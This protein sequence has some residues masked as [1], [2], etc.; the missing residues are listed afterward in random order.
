MA[1]LDYPDAD[2]QHEE[3]NALYEAI[4]SGKSDDAYNIVAEIIKKEKYLLEIH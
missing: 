2:R 3:H 1:Y 4:I